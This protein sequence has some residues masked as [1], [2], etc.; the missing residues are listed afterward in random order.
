MIILKGCCK[1]DLL[2]LD[3]L[4][5]PVCRRGPIPG[6]TLIYWWSLIRIINQYPGQ[7][8]KFHKSVIATKKTLIGWLSS[9]RKN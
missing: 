5:G 6:T 4:S 8:C 9:I 2:E 1:A 7:A 3:F